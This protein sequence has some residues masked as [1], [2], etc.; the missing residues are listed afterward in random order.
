MPA[1]TTT[2]FRQLI[3]NVVAP[4]ITALLFLGALNY[5]HTKNILVQSNHEK[6][7]II[8]DEIK[9]IHELQDLALEILQ[10]VLNPRMKEISNRLV[11]EYFADTKD[12][13]TA[14]LYRIRSQLGMNPD[15][16]DIY[17]INSDGV[18]V[19]TTFRADSGL[20]FFDF[21]LEHK[22]LLLS[23]L[24]SGDYV[25]ER[26]VIESNTKRLKKYTYHGTLDGKYIVELGIYSSKADEIIDKIR[27]RLSNLSEEQEGIESVNLFIVADKPVSLEEGV[28]I[29]EKQMP[30]Y[31]Q[32]LIDKD[33]VS[34]HT[35]E[36]KQRVLH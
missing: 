26:F 25:S 23:V 12:I 7:L 4:A 28:F 13:E 27:E 14:N 16:E 20:N 15:F 8:S 22:E 9:H 17:I 31:E 6:N 30:L 2:I 35:R 10:D 5:T 29:T 3:F 1:K 19:N 36:G 18:V 24:E 34:L 21:G 11:N 32:V 33:N